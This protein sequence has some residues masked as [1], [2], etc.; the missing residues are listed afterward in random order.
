MQPS[1]NGR[2]HERRRHDLADEVRA[3]ER[4]VLHL[5]LNAGDALVPETSDRGGSRRRQRLG[6]LLGQCR[7]QRQELLPTVVEDLEPRELSREAIESRLRF[8]L[9]GLGRSRRGVGGEELENG[10]CVVAVALP[11]VTVGTTDL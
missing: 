5:L 4:E 10:V 2:R 6:D 9:L 7:R 1:V 8:V 3:R 11:E